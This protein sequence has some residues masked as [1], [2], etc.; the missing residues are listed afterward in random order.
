MAMMDKNTPIGVKAMAAQAASFQD[1]N[2]NDE[3]AENKIKGD[4]SAA[5]EQTEEASGAPSEVE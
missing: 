5:A 2:L 1:V 4:F 3:V